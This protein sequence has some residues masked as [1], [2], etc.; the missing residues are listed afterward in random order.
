MHIYFLLPH[1]V[2]PD[3]ERIH[4]TP[5]PVQAKS[6]GNGE[7]GIKALLFRQLPAGMLSALEL[8]PEKMELLSC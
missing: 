1:C 4:Q 7:T 2:K 3:Q 8:Q 5:Q 6:D